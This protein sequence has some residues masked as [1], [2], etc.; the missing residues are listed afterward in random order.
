MEKYDPEK[1]E[2]I[3][4]FILAGVFRR[5]GRA[6]WDAFM[7]HAVI[8]KRARVPASDTFVAR[9]TEGPGL[10][11]HYFYQVRWLCH[12][13]FVLGN[14]KIYWH[15]VSFLNTLMQQWVVLPV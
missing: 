4:N 14:M 1:C 12:S 8:K 2:T 7:F 11:T 13:E 6:V 3:V 9:R 5:G 15:F 10:A